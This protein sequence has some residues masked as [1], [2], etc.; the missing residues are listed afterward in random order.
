MPCHQGKQ[1]AHV[2]RAGESS[3]S[4][5]Q[6]MM[7]GELCRV[8]SV[9]LTDCVSVRV[10]LCVCAL[11]LLRG[12]LGPG[13]AS[14]FFW[15]L[16]GCALFGGV[17]GAHRL[18]L[19]RRLSAAMYPLLLFNVLLFGVD[20]GAGG[21]PNSVYTPTRVTHAPHEFQESVLSQ[22]ATNT[23]SQLPKDCIGI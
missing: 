13:S 21:D 10:C 11:Q 17:C 15:L 3:R 14:S 12:R 1:A 4:V 16:L 19:R 8:Q 2:S 5:E 7:A 6:V 18:L 20:A 23:Y 9:E 22:H